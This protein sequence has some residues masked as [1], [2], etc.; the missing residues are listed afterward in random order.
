MERRARR[1]AGICLVGLILITSCVS[2][3]PASRLAFVELEQFASASINQSDQ[4][5]I[6]ASE[7]NLMPI[8]FAEM[9]I[10][11]FAAT[12]PNTAQP[13]AIEELFPS[14]PTTILSGFYIGSTLPEEEVDRFRYAATTANADFVIMVN[15]ANSAGLEGRALRSDRLFDD[16]VVAAYIYSAK[17]DSLVARSLLRS[18]VGALTSMTADDSDLREA[19]ETY[20]GKQA[21]LLHARLIAMD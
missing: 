17:S 18:R 5:L 13:E 20:F 1:I 19:A 8:M 14:Y 9:L 15:V 21:T 3:A 12:H 10:D 6:L 4:V 11:R 16:Y 2:I 7:A